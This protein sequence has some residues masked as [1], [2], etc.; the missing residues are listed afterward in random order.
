MLKIK[1]FQEIYGKLD[2]AYWWAVSEYK[3]EVGSTL[4]LGDEPHRVHSFVEKGQV[5]LRNVYGEELGKY[6]YEKQSKG[7][8]KRKGK[9]AN[10]KPE[11]LENTSS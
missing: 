8:K 4:K 9:R 1:D 7:T 6:Q 10:P 3:K 5:I 11:Q 2:G